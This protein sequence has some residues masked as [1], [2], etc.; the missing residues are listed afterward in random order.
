MIS[1]YYSLNQT[2]FCYIII[3]PG[4]GIVS[5]V[6]STFSGKPVFGIL[7][8]IYAMF[9]IG[10]LG[11]LVWSQLVALLYCK[12]EVTNLT[13]CWN[14]LVLRN[15]FYSKNF[16]SYTQS[17][18]NLNTLSLKS[19]SET[20]REISRNFDLFNTQYKNKISSIWLTWFIGF[21][22]GDGA[23]LTNKGRVKFVITQKESDILYHIQKVLG[24]GTVRE[25]EKFSRFTV[26]KREHI[27]LLFFYLTVI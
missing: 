9:S 12:M 23:I 3:I 18:G 25:F 7:G 13:V 15:T 27:L 10:I 2:F 1:F 26:T 14:S 11:F 6:V 4:F 5:H 20:T 17:A 16:F 21:S 22:E 19:P 8:M 24:F